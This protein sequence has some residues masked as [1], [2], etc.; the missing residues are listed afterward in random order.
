MSKR[1]FAETLP[2]DQEDV[3]AHGWIDTDKVHL[4]SASLARNLGAR[5]LQQLMH[6][7]A[8]DLTSQGCVVVVQ[9][10]IG[11]TQ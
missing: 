1:T 3:P 10:C 5:G 9:T 7:C 2:G 11:T 4:A 6:S 8:H